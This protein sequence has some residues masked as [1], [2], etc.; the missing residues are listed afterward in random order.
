MDEDNFLNEILHDINLEKELKL[1][2]PENYLDQNNFEDG[3]DKNS[4]RK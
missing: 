4:E 2:L 1:Q 3:D